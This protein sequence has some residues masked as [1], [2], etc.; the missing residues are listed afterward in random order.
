ML[1][2]WWIPEVTAAPRGWRLHAHPPP[3]LG[4]HHDSPL[5]GQLH[6]SATGQVLGASQGSDSYGE[7]GQ[8]PARLA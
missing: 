3:V 7:E 4:E 8:T 2:S 5:E 6:L 1:N